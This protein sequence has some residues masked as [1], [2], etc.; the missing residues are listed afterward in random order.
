MDSPDEATVRKL[1]RPPVWCPQ[2]RLTPRSVGGT[3]SFSPWVTPPPI[4][5]QTVPLPVNEKRELAVARVLFGLTILSLQGSFSGLS[6]LLDYGQRCRIFLDSG[7]GPDCLAR[8]CQVTEVLGGP[9]HKIAISPIIRGRRDGYVQ[10]SLNREWDAGFP[11]P[12]EEK[13]GGIKEC[14]VSVL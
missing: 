2:P 5:L 13:Q 11:A 7:A 10:D 8:L 3:A 12:G 9:W 1:A 4:L 14:Q 6:R